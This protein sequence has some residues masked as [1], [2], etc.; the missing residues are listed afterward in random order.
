MPVAPRRLDLPNLRGALTSL[1]AFQEDPGVSRPARGRRAG[2]AF[3]LALTLLALPAQAASADTSFGANPAEGITTGLTCSFGAP[4]IAFESVLPAFGTAG[5]QSCLW[6]WNNL[7]VGS[8]IVPFPVTGGAGTI[9]SVT[10]PAM[11]NP[12]SMA[13][14]VLSAAL[15]ETTN[16]ATPNSI[17]CQIKQIGPAFTVPANQVATVPQSLRVSSTEAADPNRPGDTAFYDLVGIA[18][19]SPS[20]SLPLLYTGNASS[21]SNFD[22]AYAY[23]PAPSG[24]NGEYATP[25]DPAGFRLTASFTV[26]FDGSAGGGGG[27]A[28]GG[29]GA[30]GGLKLTKKPARVG[31]DGK[32]VVLGK[33]ANPPT[34]RTVQTLTAPGA[35]RASA[36]GRKAKKPT[37]FGRGKAKI[38]A[39][40][41]AKLKLKL[42]GRGRAKLKKKGKLK[43]R[44]TVVAVNAAGEKQTVTRTVTI[45]PRQR[46]T[47]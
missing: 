43:A 24:P 6:T 36:A 15:N 25:Y 47:K 10:L 20:A 42:N 8:D 34:A 18:V 11:P 26:A 3:A 46:K 32:T 39:G 13:V 9:T 30:A 29:E 19:L 37:V 2:L 5:S 12:G 28:A 45:K 23:Y 16:P 22:G 40:K 33:A 17:C 38:A 14:V 44:L 31:A 41:S 4:Y 27:A 1:G 7:A 35:A 21:V